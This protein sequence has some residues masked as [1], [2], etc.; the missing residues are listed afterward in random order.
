MMNLSNILRIPQNK[1]HGNLQC[2]VHSIVQRHKSAMFEMYF[3]IF[4]EISK[5]NT[6]KKVFF[7][8]TCQKSP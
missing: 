7:Q 2:L 3:F 1:L 4:I 6:F 8:L 5:K